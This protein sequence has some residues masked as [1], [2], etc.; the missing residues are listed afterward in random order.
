MT[1][2]IATAIR[3]QLMQTS[4]KRIKI[5]FFNVPAYRTKLEIEIKECCD[6]DHLSV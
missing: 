6:F 3:M 5:D 2:A 4:I 1:L